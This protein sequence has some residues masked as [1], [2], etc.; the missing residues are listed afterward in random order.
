MQSFIL[1]LSLLI[2]FNKFVAAATYAQQLCTTKAGTKS[3][4]PVPTTTYALTI[5][6]TKNV[7]YISTPLSTITPPATTTTVSTTTVE[8]VTTTAPTNTDTITTTVTDTQRSTTTST[9]TE[10]ETETTSETITINGATSTVPAP[11][12]FTAIKQA[13]DYVPKIKARDALG[14]AARAAASPQIVAKLPSGGKG[15][16]L[17]PQLYPTSVICGRLVETVTTKTA[18][19]TASITSTVT[20]ATPTSTVTSTITSTSTSTVIPAGVTSTAT[21]TTTTT[22]IIPTD[23][24]TTTTTTTTATMTVLNYGPTT[25]AA[26]ASSNLAETANGGHSINEVDGGVGNRAS[27]VAAGST[28][29]CCVACITSSDNCR[30]YIYLGIRNFECELLNGDIC[31]PGVAF[32]G[33]QFKTSPSNTTP[34]LPVGNGRCGVV[35]NAGVGQQ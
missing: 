6:L 33:L 21:A 13:P 35:R 16:V 25:Y 11:P 18:T 27:F 3:I 23:T 1:F 10:T 26:C 17:S 31:D 22:L 34:G 24:T 8:T 7:R 9:A 4:S 32:G 29:D 30:A 2:F 20:A 12:G 5:T 19:K 14:L 15:A 28:Y